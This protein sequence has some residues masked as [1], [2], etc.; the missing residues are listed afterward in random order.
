MSFVS[1]KA[2][3]SRQ[4]M[5]LLEYVGYLLPLMHNALGLHV[6]SSTRGRK[7]SVWAADENSHVLEKRKGDQ[8]KAER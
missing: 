8:D 2:L 5:S 3:K 6:T 1:V 7:H 4:R